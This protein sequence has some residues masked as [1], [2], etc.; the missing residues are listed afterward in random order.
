M[1]SGD[2]ISKKS[3][4]FMRFDCFF[5]YTPTLFYHWHTCHHKR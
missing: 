2:A 3:T 4:A 1:T 5:L